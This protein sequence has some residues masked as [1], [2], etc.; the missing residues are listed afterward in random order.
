MVISM[1]MIIIMIL[2]AMGGDAPEPVSEYFP[3]GDIIIIIAA[4]AKAHGMSLRLTVSSSRVKIIIMISN[5]PRIII[6]MPW[7]VKE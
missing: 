1:I 5:D 3:S 7:H 4:L 6:M 2:L